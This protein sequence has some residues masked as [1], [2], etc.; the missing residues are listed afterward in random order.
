MKIQLP[1]IILPKHRLGRNINHDPRSLFFL[2][3]PAKVDKT[4]DWKRHVPVFDQGNVGS[5]TGNAEAG[6]LACDPFFD[7]LPSGL[8]IDQSLAVKIYSLATK[9]DPYGG[10]Y[11]PVDT[12]SDGLSVNKAAQQLGYIKGYIWATDIERAKTLIQQGPFIIGTQWTTNLDKPDINGKIANPAGGGIR[13]GHEYLCFKRDAE[14]D[15]WW[16]Y[17]SWGSGWGKS[18][19]FCYDSAGFTALLQ[20]GGDVTQSVALDKPMPPPTPPTP[21]KDQDLIDWWVLTKPWATR[22]GFS[23]TGKAGK[24]ARASIDLA[25]K[26]GL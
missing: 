4:I 15:L 11:P 26:K 20:R 22:S 13:G 19:T 17:N 10:E 1:E 5:C 18:G 7:T 16:F 21:A 9:I 25:K 6:L 3:P 8:T 24:A 2:A 23:T 14:N 12:G